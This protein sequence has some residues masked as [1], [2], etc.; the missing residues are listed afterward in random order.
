MVKRITI[1][2]ISIFFMHIIV[3][4]AGD[5][6]NDSRINVN[7]SRL[8]REYLVGN[9]VSIYESEAD[10]NGDGSVD[11]KDLVLLERGIG[12][13]SGTET[14]ADTNVS[15]K[16]IVYGQSELGRDL[17]CTVIEPKEYSRTILSI[18]AIHGFED[19]Y[20]H[21]GQ[22]LVDTAHRVIEHFK[23]PDVLQ[24]TRLM[25]ISCANPD[26]LIDGMTKN[27]YGRCN[28]NGVDLNRDFDAAHVVTTNARNYTLSPFSA[29]ESRA[30]R[31]LVLSYHPDIVLDNHGWENC[32]IGDVEIASVFHEA[33]GLNHKKSFSDNAHGYFSYWAHIQG[34]L[35]L[36]IE[37]TDP[38]FS[39]DDYIK[40]LERLASGNYDDGTGK[41]ESDPEFATFDSVKT[42]ALSDSNNLD[43]YLDINGE[44]AGVIYGS[45]D[46]CTILRF[47][48]NSWV[49]VNY[50]VLNGRRSAYCPLSYFIDPDQ[51]VKLQEIHFNNNRKVY[52]KQNLTDELGTVYTTDTA[53]VVAE[54]GTARQIFYPVDAGGWK[55][56]WIEKSNVR[57]V[58]T[59]GDALISAPDIR[60]MPGDEIS[61]PLMI[62]ADDLI[63]AR[64]WVMYDPELLE[65][66]NEENCLDSMTCSDD[67]STG[68]ICILWADS[69]IET[70]NPVNDLMAKLH[71]I[72]KDG[73]ASDTA[74]D[75]LVQNEDMLTGRLEVVKGITR[76][77]NITLR[78]DQN[79]VMYIPNNLE[80]IEEYAFYGF[81]CET[82]YLSG[83]KLKSIKSKAFS[84]CKDVYIG[85]N[86]NEIADDA[87]EGDE[88]TIHGVQGSAAE[89]YAIG[90]GIGFIS[91][92]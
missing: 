61:I 90:H 15:I 13:G 35:S 83:D 31:D 75:I 85:E 27:G 58:S 91:I 24:D 22:E 88:I 23:N 8:L 12:T 29:T 4:G 26:G 40:G 16:D 5:V 25:I 59:I 10:M 36:L 7:D 37:F 80:V 38:D 18:Y 82:L 53:Y 51:R 47:Y 67:M 89:R 84:D 21:D 20:D 19:W 57:S 77:S 14:E 87:F 43:T 79:K 1:F 49:K 30:L 2:I 48:K 92:Q 55:L 86:V 41:Y 3:Y 56:G 73:A 64:L 81:G 76:S 50:P 69:L 63:A 70:K 32:T 33:M 52:R 44:K 60:V 9:S 71:F 6:N 62:K 68:L 65:C 66:V 11:L 34:A 72:V 39:R 78:H 46:L 28:A 54:T 17:V 45:S 74:L 42:Y